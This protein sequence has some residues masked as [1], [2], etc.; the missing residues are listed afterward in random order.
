MNGRSDARSLS[1][2]WFATVCT[3]WTAMV[4]PVFHL[5]THGHGDPQQLL[6]GTLV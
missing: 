6:L 3:W 2:R 5:P 1:S 4:S